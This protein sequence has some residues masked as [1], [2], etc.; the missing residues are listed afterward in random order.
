[1]FY[2]IHRTEI[3][4]SVVNHGAG[5]WI[6]VHLTQFTRIAKNTWCP[7]KKTKKP[8]KNMMFIMERSGCDVIT[9]SLH[10]MTSL[11]LSMC[12]LN[13]PS[14]A[15]LMLVRFLMEE[16]QAVCEG[17]ISISYQTSSTT[18]ISAKRKVLR[19]KCRKIRKICKI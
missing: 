12:R 7:L 15:E 8:P 6:W 4:N 11:I 17:M 14:K 5:F 1:M 3:L 9:F 10:V 18:E 13:H 19:R 16:F 2:T